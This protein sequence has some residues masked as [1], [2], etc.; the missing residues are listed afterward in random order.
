MGVRPK[1]PA[2]LGSNADSGAYA[3]YLEQKT[4]YENYQRLFGDA[5]GARIPVLNWNRMQVLTNA[6][7]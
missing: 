4:A 7:R 1:Q 6:G 2:D 3:A 5:Q